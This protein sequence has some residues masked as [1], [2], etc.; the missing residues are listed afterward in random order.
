MS[1]RMLFVVQEGGLVEP[2]ARDI[3]S[4]RL[5]RDC[6]R[7]LR[8]FA[9]AGYGLVLLV[10]PA[11][12]GSNEATDFLV[13]LL[14]SQGLRFADVRPNGPA[15]KAGLKTG[16]VLVRFGGQDIKNLQDFTYMLQTH[17][18]GESVEVTVLRDGK[19][20]T[21]TVLLEVRR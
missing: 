18:P 13:A 17:K 3:G 8:R 7:A 10:D 14:D 21:A 6:L 4:L 19:S 11:A 1:N 16:D 15:A 12:G 20:F 2:G 9:D 5:R